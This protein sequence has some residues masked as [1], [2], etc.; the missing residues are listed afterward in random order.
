[1]ATAPMP[2]ASVLPDNNQGRLCRLLPLNRSWVRKTGFST[3]SE[4]QKGLSRLGGFVWG[5]RSPAPPP[6]DVSDE[7]L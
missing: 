6:L 2:A 4:M 7:L 5:D 1:M 3:R